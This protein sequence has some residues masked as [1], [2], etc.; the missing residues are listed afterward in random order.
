M[1]SLFKREDI[2]TMDIEEWLS[3]KEGHTLKVLS[4]TGETITLI[5]LADMD[6]REVFFVGKI[7]KE[8]HA[9]F[10]SCLECCYL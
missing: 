10:C 2:R 7:K 8:A 5:S 3:E 1:T 9:P 6:T 4:S